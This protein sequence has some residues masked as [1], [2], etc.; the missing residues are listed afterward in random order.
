MPDAKPVSTY[1]LA[2]IVPQ[3]DRL[4]ELSICGLD[5]RP[6][7]W[8]RETSQRDGGT[9]ELVIALSKSPPRITS[10][11]IVGSPDLTERALGTFFESEAAS[12]LTDLELG[13]CPGLSGESVRTLARA[14]PRLR[15]LS[16]K[17]LGLWDP[18]SSPSDADI[19][20]PLA[21][22][23]RHLTSLVSIS[24]SN[25]SCQLPS[26]VFSGFRSAEQLTSVSLSS[27]P[28]LKP[29]HLVCFPACTH[30]RVWHCPS[31]T[32]LPVG[33]SRLRSVSLFG[34]GLTVGNLWELGR[35]GVVR[36]FL[37]A[38]VRNHTVDR[39][40]FLSTSVPLDR[41]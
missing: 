30:L 26:D 37:D 28:D 29:H 40:S 35:A 4:V 22:V 20:H 39:T 1:T 31:L 17:A 6:D 18:A 23:A 27:L 41:A 32:S 13:S 14:C 21:L 33:A 38:P 9:D 34:S 11:R 10:L 7:P 25:L 36:L 15:H 19:P 24:L 8:R 5:L 2:E 16:I 3:L 12:A